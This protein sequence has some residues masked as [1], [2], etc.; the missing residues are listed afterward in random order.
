MLRSSTPRPSARDRAVQSRV[1]SAAGCVPSVDHPDDVEAALATRHG[2]GGRGSARGHRLRGHLGIGDQGVGG[3]EIA[4]G[5]LASTPQRRD[6]SAP[7]P[8]RWCLTWARTTWRA[9]RRHVPRCPARPGA[10]RTLR[11][12]WSTPTSLPVRSCFRTRYWTGRTS[13]PPT[14]AGYSTSY[15]DQVCTFIDDMQGPAAGPFCQLRH[16]TRSS[17]AAGTRM[18]DQGVVIHGSGTAGL[19][20]ADMMRD[21][22]DCGRAGSAGGDPTLLGPWAGR[23][24]LDRRSGPSASTDFPA[25]PTP[26]QWPRVAG[27]GDRTGVI[28]LAVMVEH[29]VRP[30]MLIGTSTQTGA[31]T[32]HHRADH[33]G[34][35]RSTRRRAPP[36][37]NV[38]D[39]EAPPA[40]LIF[41][42]GRAGAGG[43]G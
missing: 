25:P 35:L 37:P 42:D 15:A 28:G 32:E 34:T 8:P 10:R 17:R 40:D 1:P 9:E 33:G 14:R 36:Q 16:C 41:L 43:D 31:S 3:I 19:G 23:G 13:A 11:R 22:W 21:Q 20:I 2:A 38:E 29:R 5:K 30:T 27:W 6:P 26:A 12:V 7:G 18:R 4:I 39:A 24:L